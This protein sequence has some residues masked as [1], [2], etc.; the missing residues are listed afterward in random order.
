MFFR[1][2]NVTRAELPAMQSTAPVESE[3]TGEPRKK[4]LVVDDDPITVKTLSLT[5]KARGYDVLSA[6]NGSEAIGVVRDSNPDMMLVDVCLAP[7]VA[8]GG[9]VPWDGFQVTR[10]LQHANSKKIPAI[11][12]SGSDKPEYKGRAASVG[13][14]AFMAKPID[15]AVLLGSIAAALA[16]PPRVNSDFICLKMAN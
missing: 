4:I 8:S 7:D 5:L 10:W 14:D 3:R 1:K 9:I 6:V 2:K 12:M 15:N 16:S 13:A 11:I